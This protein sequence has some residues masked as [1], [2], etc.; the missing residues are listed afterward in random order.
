MN[1]PKIIK[2]A[3]YVTDNIL[4]PVYNSFETLDDGLEWAK[5]N[6]LIGCTV[7]RSLVYSDGEIIL[8]S[9]GEYEQSEYTIQGYSLVKGG[10]Q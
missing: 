5:K 2:V 7:F 6:G 4:A 8:G 9:F 3:Y 10:Q 1:P